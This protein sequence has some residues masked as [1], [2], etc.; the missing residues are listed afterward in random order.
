MH[1]ST[2]TTKG[3][4]TLPKAVRLALGLSRG[5]R[6]R[7][8]IRDGEIRLLKV[9]PVARLADLLAR[10]DRGARQPGRDGGGYRARRYRG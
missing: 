9:Q 2:V 4:T 3:Q 7:Y 8:V 1:E 10:P 5:D 6:V